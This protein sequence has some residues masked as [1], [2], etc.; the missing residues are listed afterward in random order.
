[1][2]APVGP[3]LSASRFKEISALA[4]RFKGIF[5]ESDHAMRVQAAE[6]R[7]HEEEERS[8]K[9]A[10]RNVPEIEEETREYEQAAVTEEESG[11]EWV[12]APRKTCA[13]KSSDDSPA[14]THTDGLPPG[15][16]A[17][18]SLPAGSAVA[19]E[20]SGADQ[21]I[22]RG[23]T[24]ASRSFDDDSPCGSHVDGRSPMVDN[25]RQDQSK[26]PVAQSNMR[27]EALEDFFWQELE[28]TRAKMREATCNEFRQLR[29]SIRRGEHG[30]LSS[31][32][33]GL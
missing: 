31:A 14:E 18:G 2:S 30:R 32:H 26:R 7:N 27:R 24:C 9:T 10:D 15:S 25:P 8:L 13:S 33:Y 11:V 5:P 17:P 1:M 20:D 28:R 21:A 6:R 23:D 12:E 19:F 3:H 22:R 29:A 4:A 16:L